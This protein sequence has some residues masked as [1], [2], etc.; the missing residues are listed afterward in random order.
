LDFRFHVYLDDHV[1]PS[2]LARLLSINRNVKALFIL[3]YLSRVAGSGG[4][5]LRVTDRAEDIPI[6]VNL[7]S[8]PS[9]IFNGR[10][11]T[12]AVL[13]HRTEE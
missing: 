7:S 9:L 13:S 6:P 12:H 8:L 10:L 5:V 2:I 4:R 11:D 1:R 3:Y